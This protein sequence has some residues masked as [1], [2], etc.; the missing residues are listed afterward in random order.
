MKRGKELP[1]EH[2]FTFASCAWGKKFSVGFGGAEM[3]AAASCR[4][5][6]PGFARRGSFA[7]AGPG[8]PRWG[9]RQRAKRNPGGGWPRRP[10]GENRLAGGL[11]P[12]QS[13]RHAPQRARNRSKQFRDKL[14]N[15][16][17]LWS[18]IPDF[19]SPYLDLLASMK[20]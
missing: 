18:V 7:L 20:S 19:S 3:P 9:N 11:K 12:R 15:G 13:N 14:S 8:F 1:I 17:R 6:W 4:P 5:P 2:S 16:N 10:R